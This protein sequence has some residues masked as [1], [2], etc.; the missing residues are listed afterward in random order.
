MTNDIYTD[1]INEYDQLID[2]ESNASINACVVL[3]KYQSALLTDCGGKE[4]NEYKQKIAEFREERNITK[5]QFNKDV[6]VG[7]YVTAALTKRLNE[8]LPKSKTAIYKQFCIPT[9]KSKTSKPKEPKI[10]YKKTTE[11]LQM[12]INELQLEIEQLKTE[13]EKQL[14][15]KEECIKQEHMIEYIRDKMG[16]DAWNKFLSKY[17]SSSSNT[18]AMVED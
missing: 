16:I 17:H 18:A 8:P 10:D 12:K 7:N 15:Y 1:L 6:K 11:E 9:K 14:R 13:D 4:T 3:Y 2:T 5:S